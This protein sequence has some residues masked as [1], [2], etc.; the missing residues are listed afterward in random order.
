VLAFGEPHVVGEATVED[1]DRLLEVGKAR[2]GALQGIDL[3]GLVGIRMGDGRGQG[4]SGLAV[5]PGGE[6]EFQP[7]V[8]GAEF[9]GRAVTVHRD[10][11]RGVEGGVSGIDGD[12]PAVGPLGAFPVEALLRGLL[13]DR[14]WGSK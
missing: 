4:L 9:D 1:L 14:L 8:V 13:G 6:V 10:G 7:A 12:D 3:R 11:H 5:D 2:E